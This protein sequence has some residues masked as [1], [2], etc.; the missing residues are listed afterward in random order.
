MALV[1]VIRIDDRDLD[2]PIFEAGHASWAVGSTARELTRSAVQAAGLTLYDGSTSE[3]G[4][5]VKRSESAGWTLWGHGSPFGTTAPGAHYVFQLDAKLDDLAGSPAEPVAFYG[6]YDRSAGAYFE[7]RFLYRSDFSSLGRFE[8]F[9]F[10]FTSSGSEALE[11]FVYS[12][13][14]RLEV[15]HLSVVLN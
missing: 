7:Y 14:D 9:R 10:E 4:W 6:L 15:D 3:S 2:P 11:P 13:G 8:P 1:T 12:Y 5:K